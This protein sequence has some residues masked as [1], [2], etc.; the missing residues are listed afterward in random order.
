MCNKVKE[1]TI[2][3][4]VLVTA[5]SAVIQIANIH[6]VAFRSSDS[7]ARTV[8][9]ESFLQPSTWA[10]RAC[11]MNNSHSSALGE[12]HVLCYTT[13]NVIQQGKMYQ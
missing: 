6:R 2:Q 5:S 8:T 4:L 9:V 10:I 1:L 3:D 7:A 12:A 13:A 11:R